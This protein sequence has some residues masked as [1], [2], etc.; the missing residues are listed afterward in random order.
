MHIFIITKY[1]CSFVCLFASVY[2]WSSFISKCISYE[3]PL[4]LDR[5]DWLTQSF[6]PFR[7]LYLFQQLFVGL[8]W[9]G[10]VVYFVFFRFL[11]LLMC[12]CE[13]VCAHE[14]RCPLS[15]KRA[16]DCLELELQETMN[17]QKQKLRTEL[18]CPA[19]AASTFNC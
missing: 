4:E 19:R 5:S 7:G 6:Q 15:P 18:R 14:C 2:S 13:Y 9:L 10:F 17:H 8:F 16:L 3:I 1:F 11:F 12:T